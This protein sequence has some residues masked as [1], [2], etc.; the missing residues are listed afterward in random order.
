MDSSAVLRWD[1][2]RNIV[3]YVFEEADFTINPIE[4]YTTKKNIQYKRLPILFKNQ[5]AVQMRFPKCSSFI[6][7]G[8]VGG[9]QTFNIPYNLTNSELEENKLF[10]DFIVSFDNFSRAKVLENVNEFRK[11]DGKSIYKLDQIKPMFSQPTGDRAKTHPNPVAWIEVMETTEIQDKKGRRLNLK[12]L[13]NQKMTIV[14]L[15]TVPFA[16]FGPHG[17][18]EEKASI[19]PRAKSIL[20]INKTAN[21]SYT[22]LGGNDLKDG[23]S[24]E[25]D[26]EFNEESNAKKILDDAELKA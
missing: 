20:V 8:S 2:F 17:D 23:E 3:P 1:R 19:K 14:I 22:D 26:D 13:I 10:K 4:T 11:K 12:D 24:E 18:R 25:T 16:F 9:K 21:I 5:P 6:I 15:V 7:E